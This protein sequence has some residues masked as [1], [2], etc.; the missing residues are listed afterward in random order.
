MVLTHICAGLQWR[1]GHGERT[2]GHGEGQGEG[3]NKIENSTDISTLSYVKQ[4]AR[5]NLLSDAG[6]SNPCSMTTQR[7]RM[8][9]EVGGRF[10]RQGTYV[11]LRLTHVDIW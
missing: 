1:C 6:S 2:F 3:G 9:W 11:Y 4:T 8:G 5:G 10:T 7:D